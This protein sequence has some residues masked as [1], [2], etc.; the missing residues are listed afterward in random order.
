M[1]ARQDALVDCACLG[2]TAALPH[3]ILQ[4][5]ADV[6]EHDC[7]QSDLVSTTAEL[8]HKSLQHIVDH[9][10]RASTHTSKL[11]NHKSLQH[12][13]AVEENWNMRAS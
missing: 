6:N 13:A 1:G 3:R 7:L 11:P 9:E 2:N 8:R 12:A 10:Y 5:I 4:H